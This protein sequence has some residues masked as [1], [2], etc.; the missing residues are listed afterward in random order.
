MF[1]TCFNIKK[2]MVYHMNRK[3][4][5]YILGYILNVEAILL[6]P[7]LLVALYY[8]EDTAFAFIISIIILFV[9]GSCMCFKKPSNHIIYAKEGFVIVALAWLLLSVFGALPFYI[10]GEIPSFVDSLF[11][12][13]SG[14]TTTG[15]SVLV[16]MEVLPKSLI[17]WR[18]FIHWIGAM[19]VLVF[20]LAIVPLAGGR[21]TYLMKAEIPGPT[22]GKLVP[23]VKKTA[24]ILYG[25]YLFFTFI[26]IILLKFGGM[27]LYDSAIHAFSTAGT[28]GFAMKSNS[29]AHYDSAYIE[30]VITVFMVLCGINFNLFYLALCGDIMQ[31]FKS[32]ELKWYLGI[33]G[34]S[35]LCISINIYPL[36]G[37]IIKTLR[38]SSFQVSSII[39]TTGYATTDYNLWPEFSKSILFV[40]MFIGGC[41]G[42]TAGGIKIARIII[43][44]KN[45][46]HQFKS[47]FHPRYMNVI[48]YEGNP[49]SDNTIRETN[50][51]FTLFI[52]ILFGSFL[53]VSIDELDF[54][55]TLTAVVACINN[56]GP[57]FGA[58]GPMGNYSEFS[59]LSKLVLSFNMLLGRLE[60]FPVMFLFAPGLWKGKKRI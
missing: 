53:I 10:S 3:M 26:V 59:Y 56:I 5:A 28:G 55:T 42:S 45:I 40:L 1:Y 35:I 16:N 17:F 41:A 14:F 6:I 47:M 20:V 46:M 8:K 50:N 29:I 54:E 18:G 13:V 51:Y 49:V 21:S 4:I 15:S 9:V 58:V 44:C 25:I 12:S 48:R 39:T 24:M 60:I 7:S 33:I 30:M 2:V 37:N 36:Y 31:V 43:I 19:G 22:Y 11:E 27:S 23:K 52:F 32:E 38:Y 57:G 34:G